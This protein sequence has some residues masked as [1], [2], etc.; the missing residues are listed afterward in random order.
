MKSKSVIKNIIKPVW[1][2]FAVTHQL[3]LETRG[4]KLGDGHTFMRFY[5]IGRILTITRVPQ[6]N[7]P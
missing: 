7:I 2:I 6:K 3:E 1:P 5:R 4:R